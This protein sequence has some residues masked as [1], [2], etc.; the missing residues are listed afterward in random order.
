M[1]ML[2]CYFQSYDN[3]L[4]L[5]EIN[6]CLTASWT[7]RT[8]FAKLLSS[9]LVMFDQAEWDLVIPQLECIT[10]YDRDA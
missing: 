5:F 2:A 3:P 1:R 6:T 9:S 8:A 7:N 4:A 10:Q